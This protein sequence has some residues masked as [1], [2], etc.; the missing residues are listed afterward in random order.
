MCRLYG[1]RSSILSGVHQSLIAAENALALQSERHRD[2]WGLAHYVGLFPHLIRNDQRAGAD[3]LYR[4]LSAVVATR[5]FV[6]HIRRATVGNVNVLNCHPFQHGAWTFAHNGEISAYADNAPLQQ[7]VR[8]LVD[9]RFRRHI[10]GSTDSEVIFHI[11][12]SQLGRMVDDVHH[13]GVSLE[14]VKRALAR[15]VDTVV[16]VAEDLPDRPC[17]LSFVLT[18][19]NVLVGYRRLCELSFSTHKT[20][21]GERDTCVAYDEMRCEREVTDGMVKHLIVASEQIGTENV[22][23]ELDDGEFVSV[24]HGMNLTRGVLS[25]CAA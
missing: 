23:S 5:T 25:D 16:E 3:A 19:G 11:F 1:F 18:N 8:A 7:R 2:G 9:E 12:L 4:E 13:L 10:L 17:K 20:R 14:H 24:D 6:A 22:W 15:T 21:C